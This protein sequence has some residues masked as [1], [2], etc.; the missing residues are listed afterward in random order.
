MK[1]EA[2]AG[3]LPAAA[4]QFERLPDSA[5]V[6]ANVAAIVLGI[7]VG[8]VWRWAKSGRLD[9]PDKIGPNTTRFQVGRLRRNIA[10]LRSPETA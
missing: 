9:P 1:R 8:T 6:S 10:A 2:T 4:E 7:S 5:G 3:N